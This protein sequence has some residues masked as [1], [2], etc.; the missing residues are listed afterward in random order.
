MFG[1]IG[2]VL[3]VIV[4]TLTAC[5][6]FGVIVIVKYLRNTYRAKHIAPATYSH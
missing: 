6:M 1:V 4:Y 2:D 3:G 5:D